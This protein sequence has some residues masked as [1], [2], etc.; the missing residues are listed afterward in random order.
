MRV[1]CSMK[2]MPCISRHFMHRF[3]MTCRGVATIQQRVY[4]AQWHTRSSQQIIAF[5]LT[6]Y[7]PLFGEILPYSR[8]FK[9]ETTLQQTALFENHV[10]R[11]QFY[12]TWPRT[13]WARQCP[14]GQLCRG[15]QKF[16][17]CRC[18][19]IMWIMSFY[20]VYF[21]RNSK[22]SSFLS[23]L[24]QGVYLPCQ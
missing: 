10:F 18:W 4:N 1:R 8:E 13:S 16:Q 9:Q 20:R 7:H 14:Y 6:E 23:F 22:L 21:Q 17:L 2:F 12:E 19:P 3:H 15:A 5:T 11:W 24:P